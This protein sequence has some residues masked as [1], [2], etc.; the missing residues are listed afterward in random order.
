MAQQTHNNPKRRRTNLSSDE[1]YAETGPF[2]TLSRIREL[3][4]T[5]EL[6]DLVLRAVCDGTS[7]ESP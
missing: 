2:L 6:T 7:D 4:E 3:W 5:G 1:L